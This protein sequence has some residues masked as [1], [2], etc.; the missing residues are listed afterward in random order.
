[1]ETEAFSDRFSTHLVCHQSISNAWMLME[2][3]AFAGKW[4]TTKGL[5]SENCESEPQKESRGRGWGVGWAEEVKQS[6]LVGESG[7]GR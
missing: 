7:A 3:G 5:L 4:A 2:Y 1:M 6:G